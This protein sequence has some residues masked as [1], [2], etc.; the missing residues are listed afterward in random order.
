MVEHKQ[1]GYPDYKDGYGTWGEKS[2][3]VTLTQNL[4]AC[5]SLHV[6]IVYQWI[7]TTKNK[8]QWKQTHNYKIKG[9][10]W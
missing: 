9:I 4:Q 6:Q 2:K 3:Q 8:Y 10:K 7:K 5:I 1:W